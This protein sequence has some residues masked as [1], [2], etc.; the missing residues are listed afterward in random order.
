MW[1]DGVDECV[2]SFLAAHSVRVCFISLPRRQD[3]W[4]AAET[5]AHSEL[6]KHVPYTQR[7]APQHLE[8]DQKV[9]TLSR[10]AHIDTRGVHTYA[11]P[12]HYTVHARARTCTCTG[13]S[14]KTEVLMLSQ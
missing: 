12:H 4:E 5:H 6:F 8:E 9:T 7:M 13:T 2:R 11:Y 14:K 10:R 3:R 1:S